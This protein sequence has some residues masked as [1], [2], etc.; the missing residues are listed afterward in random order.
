MKKIALV[1]NLRPTHSAQVT[2]D[3][4]EEF[5]SPHTVEAIAGLFKKEGYVTEIME[6]DRDLPEK[7]KN[8]RIDIVFNIAEGRGG[9]CR[10][11]LAPAICELLEIPYTGSDPLTLAATLDKS[12]AKRLMG[13][14]VQTARWKLIR[15][16][17]D[18][19]GLDL[20]F[21]VFAKPN[22][23]GSSKGIRESN[24]CENMNDLRS[25]CEFLLS[26]YRR[27][28]LVE[29]FVRGNEVTVGVLGNEDPR[30]L[31]ILQI[32]PLGSDVPEDFVYSL[33]AK[34]NYASRVRYVSPPELPDSWCLKIEA[35]AL[36]AYKLLEC[37]DVGRIDFRVT[38]DGTPF[39]I[40]ANPLPGL[41]PETG[42]LIMAAKS[43]G[44]RWEDLI[45]KILKLAESRYEQTAAPAEKEF[46]PWINCN[47]NQTSSFISQY[48]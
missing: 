20:R 26:A 39:F 29:E 34:R 5:D 30:V 43:S 32:L 9:R 6:A 40:E 12:V 1:C 7:L 36:E 15:S 17:K 10:E 11:S 47:R 4:F 42:D 35:A 14:R 48:L 19:D 31:G 37:R 33:D 18:L 27:P 3:E 41:N 2:D 8:G 13:D 38:A 28:V 21:P 25:M 44:W 46:N 45:L 16:T 24:R 22:D 23:E